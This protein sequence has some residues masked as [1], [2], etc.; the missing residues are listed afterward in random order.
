M[1]NAGYVKIN[2]EFRAHEVLDRIGCLI[3]YVEKLFALAKACKYLSKIKY[4]KT[5]TQKWVV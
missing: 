1:F 2:I 5:E 3:N 4:W